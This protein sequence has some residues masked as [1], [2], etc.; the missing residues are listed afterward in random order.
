MQGELDITFGGE[1]I[2]LRPD[3]TAYWAARRTLLVADTHFGKAAAFRSAGIPIPE[4]IAADLAKL[5]EAVHDTKAERIVVL[6]DL[7]HAASGR[8][9]AVFD[10]LADWRAAHDAIEVVLVRG[11]HDRGAGDPPG[12]MRITCVDEPWR[13]GAVDLG[14]DAARCA[15][16]E[17]ERVCGPMVVGHTH[18]AV[19]L[20]D[21]AASMARLPAFVMSADVLTLPAFGAFTGMKA[22][23]GAAGVERYAVAPGRVVRVPGGGRGR[24]ARGAK[25]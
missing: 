13:D 9:D 12:E 19:V 17:A 20:R 5:T 21:A 10:Q 4:S 18:P 11:N 6:G 22:V 24:A 7:M 14:H 8:T 23:R 25:R 1:A 15:P 16:A 2:V 3:R